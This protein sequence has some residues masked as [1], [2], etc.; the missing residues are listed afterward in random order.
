MV[1][2]NNYVIAHTKKKK[3]NHPNYDNINNKVQYFQNKCG[4]S[5]Q[6]FNSTW[7]S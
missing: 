2:Q 6:L 3:K 7:S 5:K 4:C 1:V